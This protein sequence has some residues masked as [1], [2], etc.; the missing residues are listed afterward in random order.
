MANNNYQMVTVNEYVNMLDNEVTYLDNDA[1]EIKA[2]V[3]KY[4]LKARRAQTNAKILE[5]L[6]A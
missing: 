1:K 2:S 3:E 6:L 5:A 4:L